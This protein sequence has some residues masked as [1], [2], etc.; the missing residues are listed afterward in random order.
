MSVA[1]VALHEAARE[2]GLTD[3]ETDLIVK[4]LEREPNTVEL[5]MLS[6]LWSEHCSYKHSK[7]LLRTLPTH[8]ARLLMG[9]GENAGAIDVGDGWAVAFKVESHNHPSAVEPFQ[10]AA[11]GVGGILRDIFAVGAYP[12]ALLDSLR[13]GEPDLGA[14]PLPARPRRRGDRALRQ[15]DRRPHGRRRSLLRS[16]LRAELP[17]QR[18]VHRPRARRSNDP[19]GRRRTGQ[20]AAPVRLVDRPR[21]DRRRLGP[22][23][24]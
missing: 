13:F 10:G 3:A 1:S 14:K 18:D 17:G 19:L 15:L 21:R 6:V 9:P 23:L 4:L 5:A 16:A 2:L 11:T 7:P 8:G 22:R 20:P 24:R 12:I